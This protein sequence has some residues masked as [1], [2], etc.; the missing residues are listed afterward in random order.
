MNKKDVLVIGE[1][2]VDILLNKVKG[3]PVI[4]Q[5][6]LADEMTFTLGS[7]SAIF[8]ANLASLGIPTAFCGIVGKDIFGRFILSELY[9]KLVETHLVVESAEYHTGLTMIL[10]YQQDCAKFTHR[11]AM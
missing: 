7:S 6:I 3:F 2:N 11:D 10:N 9:K 8:A 4:G 1:L 5:E